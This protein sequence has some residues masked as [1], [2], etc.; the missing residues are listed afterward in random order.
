MQIY[1]LDDNGFERLVDNNRGG[2]YY[3]VFDLLE[4]ME[5]VCYI[6]NSTK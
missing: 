6:E 5:C 4:C 1:S 3:G 2:G